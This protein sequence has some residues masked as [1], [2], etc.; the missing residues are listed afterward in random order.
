MGKTHPNLV[1][2][3]HHA[4][5]DIYMLSELKLFGMGGEIPPIEKVS[6]HGMG[7]FILRKIA[8]LKNSIYIHTF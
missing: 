5:K 7:A 2:A 8:L 4:E 6:K 3:E 1:I